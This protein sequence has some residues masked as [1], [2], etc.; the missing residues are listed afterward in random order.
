[1][2]PLVSIITPSYNQARYLEQTLQSVQW[3]DYEPLEHLVIDGGSTD[4]SVEIIERHA[5][6]LAWWISEPDRGQAEAINKG[7]ARAGGEIIAWLNSD[8]LYY[9]ADTVRRAVAA[10]EAHPVA[11]MVYADGVLVDADG[12]LLDWHR[13]PTY[14]LK[15]LL[16]FNVL[17]QPTVFMR[18]SAL[19]EAG[20]LKTDYDL[21]FDHQLWVEISARRPIMHVSEIWAVER[22]HLDAK[23]VAQ[24]ARFVDE[25]FRYV[26]SLKADPL[27]K[28]VFA[29]AGHEIEAGLHIFAGRRLIDAGQPAQALRHFA[30]ASR[31]SPAAI[32]RVWYKVVQALGSALGLEP[33]FLA[34]RRIR[35]RLQ[36][37]TQFL[38]F[39]G[40]GIH[41]RT[42]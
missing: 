8:D 36:H 7:F 21:I 42:L 2:N 14:E 3:Q 35:R 25:A 17:L 10:L 18:R 12:R 40:Q 1:M 11:G 6:R 39:D 4:G 27:F 5:D 29:A 26:R 28:P 41:W 37:R 34:Y 33:A 22:T 20:Y 16:S 9:R 24:A 30:A 32:V 23:T 19:E 13:Y 38:T 15:D 31:R